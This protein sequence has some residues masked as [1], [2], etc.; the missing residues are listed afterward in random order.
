MAWN[1]PNINI[2]IISSC[3]EA[4]AQARTF[5]AVTTIMS[6]SLFF[7]I[8]LLVPALSRSYRAAIAAH[9]PISASTPSETIQQNLG[10]YEQHAVIAKSRGAQIL[11]FPV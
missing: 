5:V 1:V 10:L 6:K 2:E 8:L 3:P 4:K 9:S 11:L 7:L